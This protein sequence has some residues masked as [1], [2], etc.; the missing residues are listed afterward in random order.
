MISYIVECLKSSVENWLSSLYFGFINLG[1]QMLTVVTDYC[2]VRVVWSPLQ[3]SVDR[4][5]PRLIVLYKS[6]S[7]S[8]SLQKVNLC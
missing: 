8:Y 6:L 5:S 7:T 2:L 4:A 1:L 3:S